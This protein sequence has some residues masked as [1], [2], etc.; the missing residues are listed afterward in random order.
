[1][2]SLVVVGI[3]VISVFIM[4]QDTPIEIPSLSMIPGTD[5]TDLLLYHSGGDSLKRGEFLVRVD[6]LNYYSNEINLIGQDGG[7]ESANSWD[8]WDVGE[9]LEIPGK[10]DYNQ[11]LIISTVGGQESLITGSGEA[12]ITGTGTPTATQ[13]T[14]P[15]PVAGFTANITSGYAPLSVLFTDQSTGSPTSW[16]W[17]FGDGGTST[18]QN[19]VHE[20]SSTGLYNVSLTVSNAYGTDFEIKIGYINVS[21]IIP[22]AANFTATPTSGDKPLNVSFTDLSTGS[23]TSWFWEFGDGY[24]S[25]GQNPVHIYTIEG[26]YSVK[27]TV[28]NAVSSDNTTKYSYITVNAGSCI[29]SEPGLKGYYYNNKDF[30]GTPVEETAGRLRL[31]DNQGYSLYGYSSDILDWPQDILGKT[32]TFSVIFEGYLV[33]SEDDTYTFNL[34]SDDGSR[35]WIDNTDDSS[36]PLIDNWGI[37]QPQSEYA[38]IY[39]TAGY[40]PV[41]IKMYEN[42]GAAVIYL[43]WRN[44]SSAEDFVT[45]FCAE[46]SCS[47]P[48]ADF[49]VDVT[50]GSAPLT[51]IFTDNSTGNPT[52]WLWN[53]GDGT[54]ST[55]QNPSHTY[56]NTGL[57]D[58]SL[59]ASN[60]NGFDYENK[61]DY[62][63]VTGFPNPAAWWRFDEASGRTVYDSS[64]NGNDGTIQGSYSRDTGACGDALYFNGYSTYVTVPDSDTL[65]APGSIT[66]TAWLKPETTS[67]YHEWTCLLDKG[68][69]TGSNY[70]YYAWKYLGVSS[71]SILTGADSEFE[72]DGYDYNY[73]E[74]QHLAFVA[75]KD[76]GTAKLYVNGEYFGATT[77]SPSS[78][79]VNNLD[80]TIGMRQTIDRYRYKG[81]MD[82]VML[83]TE[84]L[85]DNQIRSIYDTCS[86]IPLVADFHY[87]QQGSSGWVGFDDDSLGSP[88][89]WHWDF[90]DGTFSNDESPTHKF[91]KG[92][93]YAVTLTVYRDSLSSSV[94]KSISV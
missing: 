13:T 94:S 54:N 59:K 41:K 71:F 24:N 43:K 35:L 73:G 30:T 89:S 66:Y 79:I 92:I 4:G 23:P 62:I 61:T 22:P 18:G 3:A 65:D 70:R 26:T 8:S 72:V 47:P 76:A 28:S 49:T 20:Y 21:T 82:E 64:G 40:H 51:V 53:F 2:V 88:D 36:T 37:H 67:N 33:I 93:T 85:T 87:S 1:M 14:T 12:V 25:T 17:S 81:Y 58:V 69:S 45:S 16:L 90:G 60:S 39:L 7:V 56:S 19:P 80:L 74:W 77:Y 83:F 42:S 5:N 27:L 6:G 52:S 31:S 68:D 9:T 46:D 38:A 10:S 78:G 48:A 29:C 57:Y 44:S 15:G 55:E 75:D 63:T 11:V 84:A 50:S 86:A 91:N 34:T 32:N